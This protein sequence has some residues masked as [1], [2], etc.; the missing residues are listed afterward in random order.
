MA[1]PVPAGVAAA[2]LASPSDWLRLLSPSKGL[3]IALRNTRAPE[4]RL[5]REGVS[6]SHS[7]CAGVATHC[8]DECRDLCALHEATL[9][10]LLPGHTYVS[11]HEKAAHLQSAARARVLGPA[12][13][14]V[15]V[16]PQFRL[17]HSQGQL[18]ALNAKL[19]SAQQQTARLK[20]EATRVQQELTVL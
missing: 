8:C 7:T 2:G 11:T 5:A 14:K 18:A 4:M 20:Q 3:L 9:H 16:E 10:Q 19:E 12:A 17:I 6:C 13:A 15:R 1:V